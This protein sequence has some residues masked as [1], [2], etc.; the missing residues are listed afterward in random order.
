MPN[1]GTE[2]KRA[3]AVRPAVSVAYLKPSIE[4]TF[5][6]RERE[7]RRS[8]VS[9][10]NLSER[11]KDE[12]IVMLDRWP[13]EWYMTLTFRGSPSLGQ[14]F[15]AWGS[16]MAWLRERSAVP[17]YF[18]GVEWQLRGAPHFHA[19]MFGVDQAARRM[20]VVD[21]W[22]Q[23]HGI[24]RVLQYDPLLA[25]RHYVA[26]YLLKDAGRRGGDWTLEI[27]GQKVIDW[28]SPAQAQNR[29]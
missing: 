8:R 12:L 14:S 16:L 20:S 7:A 17:N 15:R 6:W 2:S 25:A 28:T 19:L 18:R 1:D 26:K 11:S 23:R 5:P 22:W 21:W 13:W 24:A 10:L 27:G 29:A 4:G 3:T 9:A